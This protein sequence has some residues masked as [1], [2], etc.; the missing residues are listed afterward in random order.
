MEFEAWEPIYER[1]REEFGFQRENDEYAR[2][3][4][5]KISP[6]FRVKNLTKFEGAKVMIVGGARCIKKELYMVEEVDKI[7]AVSTAADVLL[8]E[9][10]KIDMMV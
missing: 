6:K 2:D 10:V 5:K 4:L 1:I 7:I 3:V 9:G 8:E